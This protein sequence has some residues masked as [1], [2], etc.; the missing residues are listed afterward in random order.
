M[1]YITLDSVERF[2]IK[3]EF[4][5][6]YKISEKSVEKCLTKDSVYDIM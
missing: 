3:F 4:F 6:K 1:C 5:K 2:H